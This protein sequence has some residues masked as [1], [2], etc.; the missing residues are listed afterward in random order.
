MYTP[1]QKISPLLALLFVFSATGKAKEP[2]GKTSLSGLAAEQNNPNPDNA[3]RKSGPI[4]VHDYAWE[5]TSSFGYRQDAGDI[6]KPNDS[7]VQKMTEKQITGDLRLGHLQGDNFE[8][9]LTINYDKTDRQIG[10]WK[11]TQS[12]MGWGIG[13]IFNIPISPYQR[14]E[15][16]WKYNA[17][18]F[19]SATWIPYGGFILESKSLS[20]DSGETLKTT[21]RASELR[22]KLLFGARYMLFTH[23]ALNSWISLTYDNSKDEVTEKDSTGGTLGRVVLD[24]R[25]LSFS[26]LF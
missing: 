10:N 8:P 21:L 19:G 12:M 5:I 4:E 17:P 18:L 23:V 14:D 11:S 2:E 1:Y 3:S 9:F 16:F 7:T 24:A 26:V 20:L 6:Q 25:I 22:S 15:N 13:A